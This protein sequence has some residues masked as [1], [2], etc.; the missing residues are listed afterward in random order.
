MEPRSKS[1][2]APVASSRTNPNGDIDNLLWRLRVR[3]ESDEKT[4]SVIG[5]TS[6]CRKSGVT[7]TVANLAIRA[8]ENHMGP[9]LLIDANIHSPRH[10]RIFR[11]KG[12]AGLV[13]VLVEGLPPSEAV[14]GTATHDLDLMPMGNKDLFFTSRLE[15]KMFREIIGWAREHYRTILIDL[16]CV[17]E[18]QHT[19]LLARETDVTIVAVRSEGVR[20]TSVVEM[21]NQLQDDGVEVAGTILT[22][23]KIY[24]PAWIRRFL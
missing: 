17:S 12:A 24:T 21:I 19:L 5:V 10:Q 9:V 15:P 3:T 16:P 4:G 8:A 13:N 20:S 1:E 6:C 23:K 18:L 11:Q 14:H 22:R 7:T 2:R